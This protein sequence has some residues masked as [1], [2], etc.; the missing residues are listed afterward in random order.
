MCAYL[1]REQTGLPA[2]MGRTRGALIYED[3]TYQGFPRGWAGHWHDL[4]GAVEACRE[5]GESG[6]A[7]NGIGR[8]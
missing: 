2:R 8:C 5:V 6:P 7:V 3:R 4:S 1:E